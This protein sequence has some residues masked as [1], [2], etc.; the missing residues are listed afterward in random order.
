LLIIKESLT[1][2]QITLALNVTDRT[3]YRYIK[4]LRQAGILIKND[5]KRMSY[6]VKDISEL[7]KKIIG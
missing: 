1:I 5:R 3:V 2:G 7:R 6:Y 4:A